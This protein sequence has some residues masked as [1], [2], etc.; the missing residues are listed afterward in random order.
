MATTVGGR[1]ATHLEVAVNASACAEQS[2]DC[3][4]SPCTTVGYLWG[5]EGDSYPTQAG[6]QHGIPTDA[7]ILLWIVDVDGARIVIEGDLVPSEGSG[8][9]GSRAAPCGSITFES[10]RPDRS[11]DVAP[12][13]LVASDVGKT[14]PTGTYR[15]ASPFGKPF[16]IDLISDWRFEGLSQTTA[17]FADARAETAGALGIEVALAGSG[18]AY[19]CHGGDG[20]IRIPVPIDRRWRG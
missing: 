17:S 19:P 20:P 12:T 9:R 2:G 7:R 13:T 14:L 11:S 15:V 16:M 8:L 1:P 3:G 10:I 6:L 5:R 4:G 18:Y